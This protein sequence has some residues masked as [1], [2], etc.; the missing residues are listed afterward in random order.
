MLTSTASGKR[1]RPTVGLLEAGPEG[2]RRNRS[3]VL[4]MRILRRIAAG[5]LR[6]QAVIVNQTTEHRQRK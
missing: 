5:D 3:V 2:R 6:R 4:Q 1:S